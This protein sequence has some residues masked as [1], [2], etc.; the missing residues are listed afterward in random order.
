MVSV[1]NASLLVA[2][3]TTAYAIVAFITA[4]RTGQRKYFDSG[5]R[6]VTA[7]MILLTLASFALIYLFVTDAFQVKYVYHN[8]ASDQPLLYKI[9]GFWA[10]N[11]G[12][13]LLWAWIL[14]IY[15]FL[16][17]MF[18]PAEGDVVMSHVSVI[19][20][21]VALFFLFLINF[22]ANPF[23]LLPTIP[24]EGYGMNPLLQN[25]GMVIHPTTLYLGYVGFSVPYAYAMTA[26][27]L[28][29]ADI[30]WIRH[31]RRW[32]LAAWLFLSIGIIY[33]AQWAYVELGWGGFW[34]W[35]PVENASLLPW[36]TATAFF[37][38]VMIQE[39]RGMLKTWNILLIIATFLLT[40]F[41]TFLT[42][43][44]I[45]KSVHAFGDQTLGYYFLGFMALVLA[46][47]LY[48]AFSRLHL[49]REENQFQSV[50]SKESSFLLNNLL[51]VGSAFAVFWGTV[52]PLISEAVTGKQ[53]T[54]GPPFYNQVN[55]P[56]GI[57]L[58]ILIGICPL[59]AWRKS[60]ARNLQR[61]FLYPFAVGVVTFVALFA[62]FHFQHPWAA[63][64]LASCAFV[65]TTIFLEFLRATR[66]RHRLT[67]QG[68]LNSLVYLLLKNRQRYGGYLVHLAMITMIVGITGA[69]AFDLEV[70]KSLA[71]GESLRLGAYE[72]TY[73]GLG[74]TARGRM[75]A[76]FADLVVNKDGR[77]L[78]ILRPSKEFHPNQEEPTSEVAIMGGLRED[79]YVILAGWEEGGETAAFKV[80]VNPLIAWLW[81][82]EYLLVL[83][84][85]FAAWPEGRPA[86]MAESRFYRAS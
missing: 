63:L 85:V 68:Y 39:K 77:E 83:A 24:P 15:A 66:V 8:S 55:I 37:H 59:I 72:M 28:R 4:I 7:L 31:I 45:L 38:S 86:T 79:F 82:G 60:S 23:E 56:I 9:S 84:T 33:G 41:G 6:A 36:L 54:V 19:L 32:T 73:Q 2:L 52:Y 47:S 62:S 12:S 42:R 34:G 20:M 80:L 29:R 21:G 65:A 71:K 10:A 25:P 43:S 22:I 51:L 78:G 35:D 46:A 13:L 53:V 76:V 40:I 70:D 58:V 1:G 57:V 50:V 75:E 44:G 48:V 14:A 17:L 74:T 27:L 81:L 5:S 3:V 18:R 11:E 64:A 61:N 49:L 69:T 26:L 16:A 67:G 30:A